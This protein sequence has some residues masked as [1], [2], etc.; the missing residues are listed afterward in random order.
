[1][2]TML[3]WWVSCPRFTCWVRTDE[4]MRITDG[5]PI[6]RRFIGQGL[7][8]LLGWMEY[9]TKADVTAIPLWGEEAIR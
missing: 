5:A 2:V 1:M 9:A 8:R 7:P 3:D 6:V 4:R